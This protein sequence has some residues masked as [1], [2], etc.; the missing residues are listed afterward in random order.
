[1]LSAEGEYLATC[2]ARTHPY[3]AGELWG[4]VVASDWDVASLRVAEASGGV[5]T[6]ATSSQ[7]LG[8]AQALLSADGSRVALFMGLSG[9]L[10]A[11]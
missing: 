1:V 10:R 3:L 6:P 5:V 8:S 9:K 11:V 7:A 2:L 4:H